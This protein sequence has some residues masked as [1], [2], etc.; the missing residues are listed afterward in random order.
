L[1][2]T[3]PYMPTVPAELIASSAGTV[4]DSE[5]F[6]VTLRGEW[7]VA[8]QSGPSV[9]RL[10][11]EHPVLGRMLGVALGRVFVRRAKI[12]LTASAW[13]QMRRGLM[14]CASEAIDGEIVARHE[15]GHEM[16]FTAVGDSPRSPL[17]ETTQTRTARV[18]RPA[19]KKKG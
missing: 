4:L 3:Q 9:L 16:P 2:E 7:M 14:L 1:K 15:D 13:T 8:A 17:R 10:L 6:E 18:A 11:D 19:G 5:L 12:H